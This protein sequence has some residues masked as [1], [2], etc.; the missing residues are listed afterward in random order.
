MR[1]LVVI[2][3]LSIVG[4]ASASSKMNSLQVGMSKQDA[5]ATMGS[6][7]SVAANSSSE[8]LFYKDR[9]YVSFVNGKVDSYGQRQLSEAEIAAEASRKQAALQMMGNGFKAQ[10]AQPAYQ[11]PVNNNKSFNCTSNRV[12]SQTYT[13]CN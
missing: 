10:A 5:V 3:L 2:L 6:P 11:M 9:V 4:C 8:T 7:E 12:G 13:N 1:L